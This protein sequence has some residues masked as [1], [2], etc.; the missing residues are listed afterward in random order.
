MPIS[1][2]FW[3]SPN[4]CLLNFAWIQIF[5]VRPRLIVW[6]VMLPNVVR[7]RV[8]HSSHNVKIFHTINI[9]NNIINNKNYCGI[10][11]THGQSSNSRLRTLLTCEPKF[12]WIPEHSMHI[13]VPKFNDAQFGFVLPQS[14]QHSLP[15]IFFK[16]S[17]SARLACR[18]GFCCCFCESC[19]WR[20]F[21]ICSS[22]RL[23]HSSRSST[24]NAENSQCFWLQDMISKSKS[25]S[26]I[27]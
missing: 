27:V 5:Q 12:R 24:D 3:I 13:N 9:Y 16:A 26:E 21:S 25:S 23:T 2:Q 6:C 17:T 10:K 7:K 8:A 1:V 15:G 11:K 19:P 14:A 22:I 18:H 4:M 20:H